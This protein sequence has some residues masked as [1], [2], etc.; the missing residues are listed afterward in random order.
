MV[1]GLFSRTDDLEV[2]ADIEKQKRSTDPT[3]PT[4]ESEEK[5]V[6]H[7]TISPHSADV[8]RKLE[9]LEAKLGTLL[10]VHVQEV[11]ALRQSTIVNVKGAGNLGDKKDRDGVTTT[12]ELDAETDHYTRR[13]DERTTDLYS[14]SRRLHTHVKHL[15]DF[16]DAYVKNVRVLQEQLN[17]KFPEGQGRTGEQVGIEDRRTYETLMQQFNMQLVISTFSAGLIVSFCGLAQTL[18]ADGPHV[19]RLYNVGLLLSLFAITFHMFNIIISGRG[20]A[21]CSD[22]TLVKEHTIGY[23]YRALETCEQL[24]LHGTLFFVVAV[25]EMSFVMFDSVVYPAV[26]CGVALLGGVV[27]VTGKFRKVSV[28]YQNVVRMKAVVWTVSGRR[29][30]LE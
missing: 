16:F 5:V 12:A 18:L 11:K 7:D 3:S 24:Y 23:F 8:L 26:F 19:K 30:A 21:L 29:R 27:L 10:N 4:E 2:R 17:S 13:D 6:E 22:H 20:A 14:G 9:A 1:F 28:M 25:L 15:D